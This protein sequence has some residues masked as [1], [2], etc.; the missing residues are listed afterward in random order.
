MLV[1][2]AFNGVVSDVTAKG[3]EFVYHIVNYIDGGYL[4]Y[5]VME[6]GE[7]QPTMEDVRKGNSNLCVGSLAQNMHVNE[8]NVFCSLTV[9]MRYKLWI[10]IDMNIR[11]TLG[12]MFVIEMETCNN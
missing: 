9:G 4:Y 2:S 10:V 3:F 8:I 7:N 5:M 1:D 11:G 12:S 6:A